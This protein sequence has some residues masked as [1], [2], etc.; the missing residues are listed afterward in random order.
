MQM[1]GFTESLYYVVTCTAYAHHVKSE[2]LHEALLA[3][4]VGSSLR[5]MPTAD[6]EV[7][8]I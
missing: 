8:K 7:L 2:S 3:G 6:G 4:H 1:I 5:P